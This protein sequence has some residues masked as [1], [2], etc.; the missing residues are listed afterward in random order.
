MLIDWFTVIAQLINFV[1][2]LLLLKRFLYG[3]I[4]KAVDAREKRIA[5]Q[6]KDAEEKEIQANKDRDEYIRKNEEFDSQYNELMSKAIKWGQLCPWLMGCEKL[7]TD[8]C[9]R[10]GLG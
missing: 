10:R 9:C 8:S 5:D 4:L 3:P 7:P 1:I 6:I 2:L